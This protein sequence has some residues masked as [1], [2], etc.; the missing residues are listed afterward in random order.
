MIKEIKTIQ[1]KPKEFIKEKIE[2]IKSLIGNGIAFSALS[3]GVDSSVTTVLGHKALGDRFKSYFLQNGLMREGE[4]EMIVAAFKKLGIQ[5]NVY[6]CEDR[7]FNALK[8]IKDPEEKR[9]AITNTFYEAVFPEIMKEIGA[10]YLFQGTIY[11]DIE[12]TIAGIKRQHNVL[13]QLG[14]DT[15]VK[16][17]YKVVEPLVQLRKD[18]VRKVGKALGLPVAIFKR[19]PFPGPALAA[20]VIGEVT[21]ERTAVV[22]KATEIVEK[23]LKGIEAF[24]YLAILHEDMVTGIKDKKRKFGYQIEVRCWESKDATVARPIRL[25]YPKLEKIADKICRWIPDVV[26]VTYNI[27]AKPPST[28]E[29]V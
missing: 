11:T 29:A 25:P 17:G 14:I 23:E 7:F 12:E 19:I 4:A 21:P 10:Q 6:K 9:Q 28:I 24:Q 20:R 1:L 5:V 15:L 3:G 13:E 18:G 8:G 2:E 26:S 27:T 22:R 16:Y